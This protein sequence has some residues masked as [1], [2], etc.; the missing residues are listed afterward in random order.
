MKEICRHW[1]ISS[2]P[3]RFCLGP[4]LPCSS[5]LLSTTFA[6][7]F[8]ISTTF[9]LPFFNYTCMWLVRVGGE[10]AFH[11]RRKPRR[12]R[13]GN[14]VETCARI[15][16]RS[17]YVGSHR[18]YSSFIRRYTNHT[19]T[20]TQRDDHTGRVE[21]ATKVA[22]TRAV[23]RGDF[24][25]RGAQP[26]RNSTQLAWNS[27]PP[28]LAWNSTPP[29]QPWW[30]STQLGCRAELEYTWA[31]WAL[32]KDGRA[33]WRRC[34]RRKGKSGGWCRGGGARI[35]SVWTRWLTWRA[36][37][38]FRFNQI[39]AS[40]LAY[41]ISPIQFIHNNRIPSLCFCHFRRS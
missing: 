14:A 40:F 21:C 9:A 25:T 10:R 8:F 30:N 23:T 38:T 12:S 36:T 29:G 16:L 24:F 27:T 22:C 35:A 4:S 6:L 32:R 39:L 34:K 13:G 37:C 26:G 11:S 1:V 7:P 15:Q 33:G 18:I 5:N 28:E 2:R 17:R 20:T 41:C 19:S 3:S 31:Q